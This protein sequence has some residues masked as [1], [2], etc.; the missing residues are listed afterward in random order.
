M[1]DRPNTAELI[2]AARVYLEQELIPTLTDARLRFQ[3]L[4][5]ANVLAIAERDLAT[6]EAHLAE[7]WRLLSKLL[8]VADTAPDQLSALRHGVLEK[9]RLLCQSI[10]AG[11]F[12]EKSKFLELCRQ[13]RV[14]V[15]RKLEVANPRY[16][17][18]IGSERVARQ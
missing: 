9:N 8:N 7:E 5:A 11:D 14:I 16:L 6:E 2:A 1:N 10:L 15:E 13:L 17:A 18:G 4:V 12:D 3:T